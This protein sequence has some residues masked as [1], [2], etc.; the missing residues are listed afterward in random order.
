VR[1]AESMGTDAAESLAVPVKK[2]RAECV[3][4][5]ESETDPSNETA[6]T[7]RPSNWGTMTRSQKAH[8]RRFT[9]RR[10]K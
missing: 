9:K 10:N 4:L 5:V 7:P 8:W 1:K 6:A 2:M 3:L